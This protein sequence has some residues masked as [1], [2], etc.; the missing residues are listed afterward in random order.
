MAL[1]VYLVLILMYGF[2]FVTTTGI[3]WKDYLRSP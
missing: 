2:I 3:G 1:A